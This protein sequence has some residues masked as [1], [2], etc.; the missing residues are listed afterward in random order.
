MLSPSVWVS[1]IVMVREAALKR[2]IFRLVLMETVTR[3]TS[4]LGGLPLSDAVTTSCRDTKHKMDH[5]I[6]EVVRKKI[7]GGILDRQTATYIVCLLGIVQRLAE[8]DL[9]GSR[10]DQKHRHGLAVSHDSVLH[11]VEGGLMKK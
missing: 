6:H 11:C 5:K 1:R 9:T 10:V 3:V 4:S 7:I 2:G 8:S